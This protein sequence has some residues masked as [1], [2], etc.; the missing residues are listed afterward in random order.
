MSQL[1]GRPLRYTRCDAQQAKGSV[2]HDSS[3]SQNSTCNVACKPERSVQVRASHFTQ[4]AAGEEGARVPLKKQQKAALALA[5]CCHT[6]RQT[7]MHYNQQ[8]CC[9][10]VGGSQCGCCMQGCHTTGLKSIEMYGCGDAQACAAWNMPCNAA[11][12]CICTAVTGQQFMVEGAM[13]AD[14]QNTCQCQSC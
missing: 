9:R 5:G 7:G 1:T 12:G 13:P 4:R 10:S 2:S 11:K 3:S 14:G 6:N 8:R